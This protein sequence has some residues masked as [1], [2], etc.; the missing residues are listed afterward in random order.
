MLSMLD[1]IAEK[2]LADVAGLYKQ[3]DEPGYNPDSTVPW[4]EATTKTRVSVTVYQQVMANSREQTRGA[5]Q[6][7]VVAMQR[8]LSREEWERKAT[9]VDDEAKAAAIEAT[10]TRVDDVMDVS[11]VEEPAKR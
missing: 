8:A 11:L 2:A 6:L 3:A 1:N 7:G 10:V 4:T 9:Q 5:V